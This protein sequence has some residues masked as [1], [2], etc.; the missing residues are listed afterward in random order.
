LDVGDMTTVFADTEL[1]ER[2]IMRL[3]HSL[4]LLVRIRAES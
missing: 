4:L 3:L 2:G 1:F